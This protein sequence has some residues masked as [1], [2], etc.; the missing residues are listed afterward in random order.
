MIIHIHKVSP[1]GSRYEDE[2]P[3]SILELEHDRFVRSDGPVGYALS[4][5]L[6]SLQ[7]VVSGRLWAQV[8]LLCGRCGGFFST[9]IEVSSFLRAY[10]LSE[11]IETV[12]VTPDIR[13]DILLALPS[14]SVCS[15][16]GERGVC[17]E[18][19]V[20]LDDLMMGDSPSDENRW[21]A[22]DNLQME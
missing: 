21:G 10:S 18:S 1:D 2:E 12:D 8:G 11:G 4:A 22:L 5:H 3:G 9:R 20:N 15:W 6:A 13:E 17:P 14:F 7:L 19:G 16:K